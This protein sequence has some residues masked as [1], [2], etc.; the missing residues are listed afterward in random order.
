MLIHTDLEEDFEEKYNRMQCCVAWN[1]KFG[2]G[3]TYKQCA[4]VLGISPNDARKQALRYEKMFDREQ[5]EQDY[6]DRDFEVAVQQGLFV[7]KP[8][9]FSEA[10]AL[11][12]S[13]NPC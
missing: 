12:K 4:E 6:R 11:H 3:M 10:M 8:L 9:I 13:L 5:R 1:L 7:W 2:Q